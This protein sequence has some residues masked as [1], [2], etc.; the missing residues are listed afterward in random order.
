MPHVVRDD[1]AALA[2]C[3]RSMPMLISF[4]RTTSMTPLSLWNPSI[5]AFAP[6]LLDKNENSTSQMLS[7]TQTVDSALL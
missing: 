3:T 4:L 5:L 6:T 2:H 1:A 7:S